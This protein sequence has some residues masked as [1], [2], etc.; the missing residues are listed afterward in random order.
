MNTL[1]KPVEHPSCGSD[2]QAELEVI[3]VG[4]DILAGAGLNAALIRLTG[5]ALDYCGNATLCLEALQALGRE[6]YIKPT[7]D[8][9]WVCIFDHNGA[10]AVTVGCKKEARAAALALFF[11]VSR[12]KSVV[13]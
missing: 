4:S 1:E 2:T 5:V 7:L 8:S 6:A 3:E 13:T 11:V 12:N 9:K 10:V